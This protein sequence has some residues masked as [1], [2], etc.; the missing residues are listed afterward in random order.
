MMLSG[1][2]GTW[3]GLGVACGEPSAAWPFSLLSGKSSSW[4]SSPVVVI[5]IEG[6]FPALLKELPL[7]HAD[8]GQGACCGVS[9]LLFGSMD[10]K[11]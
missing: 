8:G 6:I 3:D 10:T 9:G 1:V 2:G 4:D 7:G 11:I 5:G